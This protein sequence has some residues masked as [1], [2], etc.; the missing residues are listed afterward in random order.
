MTANGDIIEGSGAKIYIMLGG[1]RRWIQNPSVLY[2][3]GDWNAVKN[4][5]DNELNTIP[6][7]LPFPDVRNNDKV[8]GSDPKV[9]IIQPKQRRW[10]QNPETLS[11]EGGFHITKREFLVFCIT[12]SILQ[13][14]IIF[15]FREIGYILA[16]TLLIPSVIK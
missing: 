3:L 7:G 8:K 6:E 11:C 5:S 16:F 12:I 2:S 9:Y 10:I 1:K 13:R 4:V 14:I 15:S